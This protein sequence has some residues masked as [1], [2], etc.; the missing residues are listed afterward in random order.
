MKVERVTEVFPLF[1]L[2]AYVTLF[3]FTNESWYTEKLYNS[4]IVPADTVLFT[5]TV[6]CVIHY[7]DTW[8]M[9]AKS[10]F[11]TVV[12]LN[13]LTHLSFDFVIENYY[14]IYQN[15]IALFLLFNILYEV[16]ASK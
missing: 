10:A 3:F 11:I 4:I 15:I 16:R 6:F 8:T 12:L 2:G 13:V 7:F 5:I 14:R 1:L 9:V